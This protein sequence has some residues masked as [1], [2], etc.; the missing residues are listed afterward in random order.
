[1]H[2][3]FLTSEYPHD[4][5][6]FA[7]GIGTSIKNLVSELLKEKIIVSIFVYG[8]QTDEII[9]ENGIKIHLIKSRKYSFFTWF[10]Y[11]KHIQNYINK[12]I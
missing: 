10:Y 5:I 8:Q 1:M 7:A 6:K 12:F 9:I 2:I 11:R 3:A 4:K